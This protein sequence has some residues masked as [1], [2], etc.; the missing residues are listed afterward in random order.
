M[1][2]LVLAAGL[3]GDRGRS[4]EARSSRSTAPRTRPAPLR[5]G[6][7]PA[8]ASSGLGAQLCRAGAVAG[9]CARGAARHSWA[10]LPGPRPSLCSVADRAVDPF[11]EQVRVAVVAGVLLDHVDHDPAERELPAPVGSGDIQRRG[12]CAA[13]GGSVRST[14]MMASLA[15]RLRRWPAAGCRRRSPPPRTAPYKIRSQGP[16]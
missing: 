1:I 14:V 7:L 16:G 5:P 6:L 4:A 9:S 2:Q 13:S 8:N 12:S 10:S 11:P 3:P 15:Y